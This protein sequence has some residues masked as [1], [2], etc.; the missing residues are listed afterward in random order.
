MFDPKIIDDIVQGL[1]DAV[2]QGMRDLHT[3]LQQKFRSLLQA[4]LAKLDLVTREE[5]DVQCK[6]L[7]RTRAKIEAIERQL[8]ELERNK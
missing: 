4:N 2:P 8:A 1:N 5:F 7:A 6:V 3:D